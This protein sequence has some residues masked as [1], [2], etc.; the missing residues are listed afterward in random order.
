[1]SDFLR[2][3]WRFKPE[4]SWILLWSLKSGRSEFYSNVE[5]AVEA[6]QRLARQG[7]VYVGAGLRAQSLPPGSRGGTTDVSGIAALW[8]DVD[9]VDPV[10]QKINLFPSKDEAEHFVLQVTPL[11]PSY[12]IDTGHG[13]Q[14]WWLFAE[15]WMFADDA[16]RRSAIDLSRRWSNTFRFQAHERHLDIDAVHD[17][18]R[19]LRIPDTYNYKDVERGGERLLVTIRRQQY[20]G[21]EIVR[22][23]PADFE[24]FLLDSPETS[25]EAVR[26]V[27]EFII[28]LYAE[29]PQAKF[30]LLHDTSV[31]FRRSWQH[32]R[33]DLQDQSLSAYD[34]S[35]ASIAGYAGWS[36]QEIVDLIIA[37][38]RLHGE[39]GSH[40]NLEDYLRRTLR[41]STPLQREVPS[42]NP[43][44]PEI[45]APKPPPIVGTTP[46]KKGRPAK[47][48]E[49]SMMMKEIAEA[50]SP[51][52]KLAILSGMLGP[53]EIHGIIAYRSEPASY[54]MDTNFGKIHFD[55]PDTFINQA[56]F[57]SH[58][59]T[60]TRH[61]PPLMKRVDWDDVLNIFGDIM[62]VQ[63]IA[64]DATDEG[65]ITHYLVAYLGDRTPTEK[66]ADALR[67]ESSY[68]K[69]GE[70]YV[71]GSALR[72]WIMANYKHTLSARDFGVLM[73][74]VG[75]IQ[76]PLNFTAEGGRRTTKSCW[77]VPFRI[78]REVLG[79]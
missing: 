31:K 7:D 36:T 52:Q 46:A 30:D 76:K 11:T 32:E 55:K 79:D 75:S 71:F 57:R 72:L 26:D 66:E 20:R 19:V 18:S 45:S 33:Q 69:D 40:K 41:R 48:T 12:V 1:M 61:M 77:S 21:S 27:G 59:F 10:H 62:E 6:S 17:L 29:V 25:P 43:N 78:V 37:H 53:L 22:Y 54:M 67:T 47:D 38:R 49:F 2:D 64:D 63:D 14:M 8:L 73:R 50:E 28:N 9:V 70:I 74:K 42:A 23:A 39:S 58:L 35:L 44:N 5:P 16:E 68:L 13:L 15:P 24:P 4:D 51:A 60:A 3:L 65:I 34:M 56:A